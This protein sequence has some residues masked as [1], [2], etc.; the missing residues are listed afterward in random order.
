M[1]N[2]LIDQ[3]DV[4]AFQD[5]P[6]R[7]VG[8]GEG[9]AIDVGGGDEEVGEGH[10]VNP[11]EA[12]VPVF[13]RRGHHALLG[14]NLLGARPEV[15]DLDLVDTLAPRSP[16]GERR[17]LAE[18]GELQVVELSAGKVAELFKFGLHLGKHAWG[19][20]ALDVA[21]EDPVG[22]VL[23]VERRRLL[24]EIGVHDSTA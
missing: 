4:A 16:L 14:S 8:H 21:F 7:A 24:H 2:R 22:V 18:V 17:L 13:V 1:W 23:V 3:V 5:R 19:E 6:R 12:P 15:G 10:L 9:T 11:A 20:G